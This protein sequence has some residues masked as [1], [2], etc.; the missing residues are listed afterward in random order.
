MIIV[1]YKEMIKWLGDRMRDFSNQRA[2]NWMV[3]PKAKGDGKKVPGGT[4]LKELIKNKELLD[5]LK[6]F[7]DVKRGPDVI[8]DTPMM[9]K[10][11]EERPDD[12]IVKFVGG[13]GLEDFIGKLKVYSD[14]MQEEDEERARNNPN[15]RPTA[16]VGSWEVLEKTIDKY[17][18]V[19]RKKN[20]P[21]EVKSLTRGKTDYTEDRGYIVEM[22]GNKYFI[23]RLVPRPGEV[24]YDK[25][26]KNGPTHA[27]TPL[28]PTP[29]DSNP[30]IRSAF[31]SMRTE[32]GLMSH[33]VGYGDTIG[34]DYDG[35]ML[36][37]YN[38]Y[39][40][41]DKEDRPIFTFHTDP[42]GKLVSAHG[43]NN[44][45]RVPVKISNILG[46]F[47]IKKGTTI[48]NNDLLTQLRLVKSDDDKVYASTNIPSGV[49]IVSNVSLYKVTKEIRIGTGVTIRGFLDIAYSSVKRL[50]AGLEVDVLAFEGIKLD[51][52]SFDNGTSVKEKMIFDTSLYGDKE[53]ASIYGK[54]AKKELSSTAY[55]MLHSGTILSDDRS[56]SVRRVEVP[57]L[58]GP[59]R[60]PTH[61]G[62]LIIYADPF[63][64][65]LVRLVTHDGKERDYTQDQLSPEFKQM[66]VDKKHPNGQYGYGSGDEI[67][68]KFLED[69][70]LTDEEVFEY[71][72]ANCKD[73]GFKT[74]G[75]CDIIP[76]FNEM[77]R[78]EQK[79]YSKAEVDDMFRTMEATGAEAEEGSDY[80]QSVLEQLRNETNLESILK[81]DAS[82][83]T[84]AALA[85][86]RKRIDEDGKDN[87]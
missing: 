64:N 83:T 57:D 72:D 18:E 66:T 48:T 55:F 68:Q 80:I 85:R 36:K 23:V 19:L 7:E 71:F 20:A 87:V 73:G 16:I 25:A 43:Y 32:S 1:N 67:F 40:V 46:E 49:T 38:F 82:N 61:N 51:L 60:H 47:F 12:T 54:I 21:V 5:R 63:D 24:D 65:I 56:F 74:L 84:V 4:G 62:F 11:L 29:Y 30:R 41:R 3:A 39:S 53:V 10:S 45:V 77:S 44:A 15:I 76:G 37:G 31:Y 35:Q 26:G 42:S 14:S 33:C 79:E 6:H 9:Q 50:P 75:L 34:S 22:M 28:F 2:V 59:L 69:T 81:Y 8:P 52:S 13:E 70:G 86:E 27:F 58:E 17:M 78:E